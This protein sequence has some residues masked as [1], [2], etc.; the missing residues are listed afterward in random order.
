[1][2]VR[3]GA[4]YREGLRD[5]RQIWV[6]GE[7]VKDV[8]RDPRFST[9]VD[10]IA[11][12]YDL[13]CDPKLQDALTYEEGGESFGLSYL[14]PRSEADLVRRRGMVKAWMDWTAGMMGRSPDF[15]NI[16]MTGF[17][18]AQE[19]FARGGDKFGKNIRAYWEE[20]R[21]S[22]WALTHTLI[23]PQTD[24]SKP[25]HQQPADTAAHIIEEKDSGA[26]LRGA[27]MIATLA[28]FADEL[29]VFPSTFLEVSEE[30]KPYA[31]A[32][33]IPVD[34]PGLKFI[35]RPPI[36]PVG[37]R[38]LDYPFSS[39]LDEM[40][41]VVIFDDVLIPWER[42]FVYREPALA[43]QLFPATGTMNQIMHQFA[44]KNQAKAE[45]LLGLA[46]TMADTIGIGGFPNVQNQLNE[47]INAVELVNACVRASEADCVPGPN[48]TVLPNAQPLWTV[49]TLFPQIYPRLIEIIQIL[50]AS[51]LVMVPSATE[52][53]GPLHDEIATYY[54]GATKPADERI[55]IFR[56]AW[57][58]SV[59]G[60]GG[61]QVLYERY[62]SG[63][64]WR[65]GITRLN[66]YPRKDELKARVTEFI[67]R[68]REWDRRSLADR[69][70][71]VP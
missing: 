30:A 12:L 19:Y 18:S 47:M 65:L 69:S 41:T 24:R 25:V 3:S 53:E 5:E 66:A 16:H 31:F 35:C 58:L 49:R 28:P 2:A 43:N 27:R 38:V 68:T 4:R 36:T 26:V 67:A 44:V 42:F 29:A 20:L 22:D 8:T 70:A 37:G 13:Q 60:F 9:V 33:C 62:F 46:L 1:M 21:H 39:R 51:G 34:T 71:R 61:R 45:F 14:E 59:S 54:Q 10:S 11:E 50:G 23:N 55:E 15:M 17:A 40:D 32:F 7:R 52:L 56:M 6:D 57:D 63:D 64:P 48:G